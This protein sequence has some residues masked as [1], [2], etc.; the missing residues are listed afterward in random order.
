[1]LSIF[2]CIQTVYIGNIANCHYVRASNEAGK[3]GDEWTASK[4]NVR[5]IELEHVIT[6]AACDGPKNKMIK[7]MPEDIVTRY[8]VACRSPLFCCACVVVTNA[9]V[10]VVVVV[11]GKCHLPSTYHH[12]HR[13]RLS[14]AFVTSVSLLHHTANEHAALAAASAFAVAAA[15]HSIRHLCEFCSVNADL[16]RVSLFSNEDV[17]TYK[18]S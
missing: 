13:H 2:N 18:S 5:C 9:V 11:V 10:V 12:H 8:P 4:T 7:E 16:V 1:M 6:H 15:L 17:Y 14:Y 3:R